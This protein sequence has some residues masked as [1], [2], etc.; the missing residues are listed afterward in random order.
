[1][2]EFKTAFIDPATL[3]GKKPAVAAA[4]AVAGFV[5]TIQKVVEL[6]PSAPH[7]DEGAELLAALSP[8]APPTPPSMGAHYTDVLDELWPSFGEPDERT[9][10]RLRVLF[11]ETVKV[12]GQMNTISIDFFDRVPFSKISLADRT[13][14]HKEFIEYLRRLNEYRKRLDELPPESTNTQTIYVGLVKQRQGAG[15]VPDAIMHLYFAN[16]LDVLADHVQD[17]SKGFV[18]RVLAGLEATRDAAIVVEDEVT[19]TA[20]EAVQTVNTWKWGLGAGIAALVTIVVG[21]LVLAFAPR[22][23][24]AKERA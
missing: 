9:A 1:M 18:A 19:D 11:D 21:S 10:A 2:L 15:P 4:P 24:D 14:F 20:S 23:S 5:P 17:M 12:A 6:G 13:R 3:L 22:R 8:G 7:V 16:Q